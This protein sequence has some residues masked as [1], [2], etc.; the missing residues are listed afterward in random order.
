[1]DTALIEEALLVHQR[2]QLTGAE[3]A[4]ATGVKNAT[5]RAW[6]NQT[7]SPSRGQAAERLLE[8]SSIVERLARVMKPAYIS[9]WLRR[10]NRGL[11]HQKPIDLIAMGQFEEVSRLVAG[12]ESPPAS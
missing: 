6:L 2:G 7:R 12:L 11:Q 4:R 10:P 1:M 5:V 9:T 8:L 3:I